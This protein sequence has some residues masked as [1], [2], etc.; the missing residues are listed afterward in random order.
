[1]LAFAGLPLFFLEMAFGQ[2]G[3]L[4][5]ISVWAA[6]PIFKGL[7][8]AMVI[9]SGLVCIYYN[10]IIA[11]GFY[12]LFASFRSEVPWSKCTDEWVSKYNCSLRDLGENAVSKREE[13]SK[14][15]A[16]YY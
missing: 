7:G 9:I 4:G 13:L 11:Y 5:P 12:Y 1:M 16:L 15:L 8:Y 14:P 10:M 2:Y 6:M 3:S